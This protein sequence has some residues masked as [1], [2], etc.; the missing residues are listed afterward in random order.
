GESGMPGH[1][2]SIFGGQ[3]IPVTN[4]VG[5]VAGGTSFAAINNWGA[6][7]TDAVA[8]ANASA[9]HNNMPPYVVL[10]QIIKVTGA[11]INA[12]GALVGPQGP[13]GAPGTPATAPL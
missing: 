10:A 5:Q 4:A 1:A 6:G 13:P 7:G 11:Q 8:A 9:A 2:H 3:L 12:G